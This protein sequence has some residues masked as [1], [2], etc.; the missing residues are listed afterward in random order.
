MKVKG[1]FIFFLPLRGVR[2]RERE[3]RGSSMTFDD[4]LRCGVV[5]YLKI[6]TC[7]VEQG[8]GWLING[9]ISV[10]EL[11]SAVSDFWLLELRAGWLRWVK[12]L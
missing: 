8:S 4:R 12:W 9:G 5:D 7:R 6:I 2:G 3:T 1:N 10:G 11:R